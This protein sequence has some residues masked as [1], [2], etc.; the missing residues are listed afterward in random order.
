MSTATNQEV[1]AGIKPANLK[2][3]FPPREI[4]IISHINRVS[5]GQGSPRMAM[6]SADADYNGH[7]V[8]VRFNSYRGYWIAEYI[9]S[10]R[11]VLERGSL[12]DCLQAAK[13]EQD[14]GALGASVAVYIPMASSSDLDRFMCAETVDDIASQCAAFGMIQYDTQEL[15]SWWTWKHS[16]TCEAVRE[17]ATHHL[18]AAVSLDDFYD[19][20]YGKKGSIS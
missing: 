9:R 1:N 7:S 17:H 18:L 20:C 5:A 12:A 4:D 2:W 6:A 19:R 15:P 10:G 13:A 16:L 14:R 3:G 11:N 8:I